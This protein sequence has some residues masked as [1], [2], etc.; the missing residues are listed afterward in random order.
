V[1]AFVEGGAE[2]YEAP[3]EA[4]DALGHWIGLIAPAAKRLAS[5][6]GGQG[7]ADAEALAKESVRQSLD[8]LRSHPRLAALE[9]AGALRLHG[10]YFEIATARLLALDE[11]SGQFRPVAPERH[12]AASAGFDG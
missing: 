8:N 9:Q 6:S 11:A 4:D 1:R 10:A 3:L 5:E 7:P 12:K 2:K